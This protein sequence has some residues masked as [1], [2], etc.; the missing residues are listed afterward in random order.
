MHQND[1]EREPLSDL[2]VAR[3][4]RHLEVMNAHFDHPVPRAEYIQQL[5]G[6]N[7]KAGRDERSGCTEDCVC[8]L[9]RFF[10]HWYFHEFGTP[11]SLLKYYLSRERAGR[12][13][14]WGEGP[15]AGAACWDWTP[16]SAR[17]WSP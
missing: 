12:G 17:T 4:G 14:G 1:E 3:L 16:W 2:S 5:C 7:R 9:R 8:D 6:T 13:S 11:S 15:R 10:C